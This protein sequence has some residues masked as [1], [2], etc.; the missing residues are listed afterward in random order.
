MAHAPRLKLYA[1]IKGASEPDLDVLCSLGPEFEVCRQGPGT[2]DIAYEGGYMAHEEIVDL[3]SRSVARQGRAWIDVI[4]VEA[5]EME[6]YLI[7]PEGTLSK[8][9]PLNEALEGFAFE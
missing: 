9:I 2:A 1:T 7:D 6:R 5:W 8:T 4:D 3:I